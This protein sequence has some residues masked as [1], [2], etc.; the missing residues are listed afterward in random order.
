LA[1][2]TNNQGNTL[3][4]TSSNIGSDLIVSPATGTW[5]SLKPSTQSLELNSKNSNIEQYLENR[6]S[7][8]KIGYSFQLNPWGNLSG[9]NDE[10][11]PSSRI[12]VKIKSQMPLVV[13]ADG[14]TLRDTF[15]LEIPNNDTKTSIKSAIFTLNAINAF[16]MSCQPILYLLDENNF[17]LQTIVGTIEIS[18]ALYGS[19]DSNDGLFKKKSVVQF[20]LNESVSSSLNDVKKVI[21]EGI[22]NTPTPGNTNTQSHNIPFGAFLSVNLKLKVNTKIVL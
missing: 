9:G 11:F 7:K 18:S 13:G 3:A 4:L 14:L 2:N 5:N 16:P 22:F 1:E 17:I 12:K 6:G 15:D 19:Q 8:N 20:I 21:V 10:I